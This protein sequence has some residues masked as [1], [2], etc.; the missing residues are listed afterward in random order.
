MFAFAMRITPSAAC[1]S[2]SPSG[3]A[4]FLSM[5]SRAA[6]SSDCKSAARGTSVDSGCGAL[7]HQAAVGMNR[8]RLDGNA[9]IFDTRKKA[10]EVGLHART[11]RRIEPRRRPAFV[12][13][14]FLQHVARNTHMRIGQLAL[15]DAPR[16]LFVR[17]IAVRM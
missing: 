12:L 6:C 2:A 13:A 9:E 17:R 10:F 4:T 15:D 3:C 1:S 14:K 16:R 7:R 5:T 11:D 8:D